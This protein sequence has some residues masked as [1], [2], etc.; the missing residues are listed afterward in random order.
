MAAFLGFLY[1]FVT[2]QDMELIQVIQNIFI[3]QNKLRD[4]KLPENIAL[5]S[6]SPY[7]QA[8]S[9]EKTPI[10]IGFDG[11]LAS[12][13]TFSVTDSSNKLS[14]L[15]IA[16]PPVSSKGASNDWDKH[17]SDEEGVLTQ[18]QENVV[19]PR[20]GKFFTPDKHIE[21]LDHFD[22]CQEYSKLCTVCDI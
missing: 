15:Q 5:D 16:A 18:T 10:T 13:Q 9:V 17:N 1:Y 7:K 22:E 14:V 11:G 8:T 3:L 21:F 6:P 12:V 2:V 19:C 20:C 4:I